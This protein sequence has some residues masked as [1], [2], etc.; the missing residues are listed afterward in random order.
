MVIEILLLLLLAAALANTTTASTTTTQNDFDLGDYTGIVALGAT[1]ITFFLTYRHG[2]QSEQTRIARE[3]WEKISENNL[4]F[5]EKLEEYKEQCKIVDEYKQKY[6]D[7]PNG[8]AKPDN[9]I[10]S[11]SNLSDIKK[12]LDRRCEILLDHI[13]YYIFLVNHK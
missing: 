7:L 4:I 12:E 6:K 8:L 3:T 5:N 9:F 13:E 2:T 10:K 1:A 11:E